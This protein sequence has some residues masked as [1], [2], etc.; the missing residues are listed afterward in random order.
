MPL[1]EDHCKN[2]EANATDVENLAKQ[3]LRAAKAL[4]K[5][6]AEGSPNKIRAAALQVD[7]AVN[8]V[9]KVEPTTNRAWPLSDSELTDLLDGPYVDQLIG[10]ASAAGVPM[11]RLDSGRL[12]AFPVIVHVLSSQRAIRLDGAR[13]T[14][15][16]PSVVVEVIRSKLKKPHSHPDKFIE[17]LFKAYQLVVGENL[18]RGT[19]LLNVYDALTLLPE[20]RNNY[21]KA[22]FTRD[23]YELE[24]SSVR[25]TKSGAAV[26]F[27]SATGTKSKSETLQIISPE[28]MPKYYYGIRFEKGA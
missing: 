23:V 17:V 20:S 13:L 25:R 19:T 6:A 9:G 27:P 14:G 10:A 3:M 5:A 15:L 12:A 8:K 4:K 26:S 28:G 18:E 2:A 21:G 11:S 22:E 24:L 1:F 16:R 7:E